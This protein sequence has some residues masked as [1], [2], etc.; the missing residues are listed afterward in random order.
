MSGTAQL[1]GFEHSVAAAKELADE[2]LRVAEGVDET[3]IRN[4][5]VYMIESLKKEAVNGE[6]NRFRHGFNQLTKFFNTHTLS[7][8]RECQGKR[9][10]KGYVPV[11]RYDGWNYGKQ[12]YEA[13]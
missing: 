12:T 3:P 9:G 4:Q 5:L 13:V 8:Y 2:V 1:Y 6:I 7:G 10:R 11:W